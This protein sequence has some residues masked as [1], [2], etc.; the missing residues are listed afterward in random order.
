MAERHDPARWARAG[1]RRLGALTLAVALLA[2]A[3]GGDDDDATAAT[4]EGGTA[5]TATETSGPDAR[6]TD[7]NASLSYSFALPPGNIDPAKPQSPYDMTYL[8][9]AYDTLI[10]RAA[11]GTLEPRLATSFEF[12][13]GALELK[14]R[15]GVVFHDGSPFNAEAV[16]AN[17][18][19]TLTVEGANQA[20]LLAS[21]AS[22][23]VVDEYTVRFVLTSGG[24]ELPGVLSSFPGVMVSPQAFTG[25]L[26]QTMVGTGA[27]QLETFDP[28][29]GVE[30]VPFADAWNPDDAA[31]GR[32]R[33]VNQADSGQRLNQ[34]K[35]GQVQA[36]QIDPNLVESAEAEGM[37]VIA[38]PANNA[39]LLSFN[40]R[41][42]GPLASVEARR[43][44]NLALDR[45]GMV[46]ALDFGFATPTA[47]LQPETE[48]GHNP[49]VAPAYDPDEAATLAEQSGLTGVTLKL[50][51]AAIP[52]IRGYQEAVQAQLAAI[53]VNSEIV[54]I[55]LARVAEEVGTGAWD[56]YMH[57]WPGAADPWITY[58][59]L[60]TGESQYFPG[61]LPDDVATLIDQART[62]T[63]PAARTKVL[64]DLA[65]A[66][67]E[68]ELLGLIS[69]ALRPAAALPSVVN[70]QGLTHV[71]AELRGT[72]LAAA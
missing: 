68:N 12:V 46:D 49:D 25:D 37:Q 62:E 32:L 36:A 7:P 58:S 28:A 55:E 67:H 2:A 19:R 10:H 18:E 6:A 31:A 22:V 11:D 56:L 34:L 57:F 65:A 51:G 43:A 70:F 38:Q 48:D 39:W 60:L 66:V 33:I 63:D 59:T 4:A 35:T 41:A 1:R 45:A 21:V 52:T 9:P 42:D 5:A 15:E 61:P 47:Q 26:S 29:A 13:D 71:I 50:Y 30:Y 24:A 27:Y 14:L 54:E 64:Q 69:T 44:I 72:G 20:A 53:G 16:K 8:R 3:C 17:I 40:T 23:E